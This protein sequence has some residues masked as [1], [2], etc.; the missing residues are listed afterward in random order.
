MIKIVVCASNEDVFWIAEQN[1]S[2][3]DAHL[4]ALYLFMQSTQ[5]SSFYV[6]RSMLYGFYWASDSFQ[7]G[8]G[9]L[10]SKL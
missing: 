10:Q 2:L 6:N 9:I 4:Y 7:K 3:Y 1:C 5:S 8:D